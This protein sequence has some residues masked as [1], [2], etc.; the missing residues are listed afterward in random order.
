MEDKDWL[1]RDRI[2]R[3]EEER[4]PWLPVWAILLDAAERHLRV[5]SY[6][7][8]VG[9]TVLSEDAVDEF[10]DVDVLN[11]LIQTAIGDLAKEEFKPSVTIRR[12]EGDADF[13]EHVQGAF[14]FGCEEE[15]FL[16]EAVGELAL[17][18]VT[19]GTCGAR[20]RFDPAMGQ[21]IVD[22]K[23]N[24]ID[25]PHV[26]GEPVYDKPDAYGPIS[27]DFLDSGKPPKVRLQPAH[28][29]QIELEV[30]APH[31]MLF[32]P[33]YHRPRKFPWIGVVVAVPT[34]GLKD[35]WPEHASEIVPDGGLS[36]AYAGSS[37]IDSFINESQGLLDDHTLLYEIY[38]NPT[39][40]YPDGRVAVLAGLGGTVLL[41]VR[42]KLPI[43]KPSGMRHSGVEVFRYWEVPGRMMGRSP[44]SVGAPLARSYQ[45]LIAHI[46]EIIELGKPKVI[47]EEGLGPERDPDN[48]VLSFVYMPRGSAYHFFEGVGP[49]P[50]ME[51]ARRRLLGE[52]ES[53][54]GKRQV[55]VGGST[56]NTRSYSQQ[57]ALREAGQLKTDQVTKRLLRGVKGLS[58]SLLWLMA[59]F[60]MEEKHVAVAGPDGYFEERQ[61]QKGR[62]KELFFRIMVRT[63]SGL[64]DSLEAGMVDR[65]LDYTIQSGQPLPPKMVANIL[66]AGR[67]I[68]IPDATGV[69]R[70]HMW[71]AQRENDD[72]KDGE[73]VKAQMF[74]DHMIHKQIHTVDQVKAAGVGEDELFEKLTAHIQEH[75]QMLAETQ[76][77]ADQL[78]APNVSAD[79]L[80]QA[81]GQ[82]PAPPGPAGPFPGPAGAPATVS[83]INGAGA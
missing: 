80:P 17:W 13:V 20:A 66:K 40:E 37:P 61:F 75:D 28:E 58:E 36:S 62:L 41:D 35:A 71:K 26:H 60:W 67:I 45:R 72:F 1:W 55:D 64:P 9:G 7:T 23:G 22:E 21:Q 12:G 46:D 65:F 49:G 25:V 74:D 47:M 52:M 59:R 18:L 30:L 14:D 27:A 77:M 24:Q 15:W 43:L 50:W 39:M 31:Q 34:E 82:P 63:S 78:Q 76:T 29:G 8:R 68:E 4:L 53:S 33:G 83:P 79:Q 54:V 5:G 56:P 57:I 51:E 70:V 42:D 11:E 81:N 32:P 6:D 73:T 10:A 16:D 3:S 44:L 2:Q 48:R 38:E 19:I 69:E